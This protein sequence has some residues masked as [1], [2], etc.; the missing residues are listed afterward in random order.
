LHSV[1]VFKIWDFRRSALILRFVVKLSAGSAAVY[2]NLTS[3]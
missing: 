3:G 2:Y 1:A